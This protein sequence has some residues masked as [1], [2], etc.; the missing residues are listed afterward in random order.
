MGEDN[1]ADNAPAHGQRRDEN[2][3]Y[4]DPFCDLIRLRRN[5]IDEDDDVISHR[6]GRIRLTIDADSSASVLLDMGSVAGE[7]DNGFDFVGRVPGV[8]PASGER[9]E[10]VIPPPE[11]GNT[12]SRSFVARGTPPALGIF[13]GVILVECNDPANAGVRIPV[14]VEGA[15]TPTAMAEIKSIN[16]DESYPRPPRVEPLDDV[17]LSAEGSTTSS[18]SLR[19]VEYRRLI[20]PFKSEE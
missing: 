2:R 4:V 3:L 7:T 19:I 1:G 5:V 8:D 17:M 20:G 16:G 13:N 6:L 9:F 12:S 10:S 18:G 14:Q 11:G 15:V